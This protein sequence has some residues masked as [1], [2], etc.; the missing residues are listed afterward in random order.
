MQFM[1]DGFIEVANFFKNTKNYT[2]IIENLNDI[3]TFNHNPTVENYSGFVEGIAEL[4]ASNDGLSFIK[5]L[6]LETG[7]TV[8]DI[9]ELFRK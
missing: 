3:H 6:G 5:D 9:I 8:V 4:A 2:G 1:P 7:K